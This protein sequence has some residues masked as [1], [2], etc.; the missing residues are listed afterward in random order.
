MP[1]TFEGG[2]RCRAVRYRVSGPPKVS[3]V[4]HCRSCRLS[5]G[6]PAVAWA[7]WPEDR[8]M[9]IAGSATR[10]SSSPGVMRTF[11]GQCGTPLTYQNS[12]DGRGTIDVTTATLDDADAFPPTMEIWTEQKLR[13][14]CTNP[15]LPHHR[16][17]SRN[18]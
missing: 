16:Q 17:S 6:A 3:D 18:S 8:F 1:D 12:A 4:C 10:Y 9:W 5:A 13:W 2:C 11:C 15:A 7:V 14:Q